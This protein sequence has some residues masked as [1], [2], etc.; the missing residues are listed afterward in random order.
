MARK[1]TTRAANGDG[2]IRQRPD[3]RWEVRITLGIDP[4]TGKPKRKSFYGSTQSE[5]RRKKTEALAA[6]DKG[7]YQEPS[8]IT[9]ESW[10]NTWLEEYCK[11]SVK[12][13]TL[14]SYNTI[15]NKHIIPNIGGLRLQDVRGVHIQKMYNKM[16]SN[17]NA[18]K[19]VKNIG[20]VLHKA[21]S[22]AV[23]QGLVIA[24]PCDATELPTM[25]QHEINPLSDTEIPLFIQAIKGHPFE[26]AYMLCLTLG[27]REGECLG[28]PWDNVD[29]DK[30]E[31][32]IAQQ[33]QKDKTAG[34][35]YKIVPFT[36]SNKPRSITLPPIAIECLKAERQKQRKNRIKAGSKWD[37]PYNLVFTNEF[38]RHLAIFTFYNNFKKVAASIGRPDLRP[39]DLRH[40]AATIVIAQGAD[41]KSVQSLLGHATA[42]FTLNVYA[43]T[44]ERMKEDTANRM[45]N[46]FDGVQKKG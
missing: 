22:I 12:P 14:S 3:G 37:N 26:G 5:V 20:A 45:Q 2:S 4:A 33:L 9:V 46:Y 23:K 34:G 32:I 1:A 39:H 29:L 31:L 38:G 13:Y 44:T 11:N 41:V 25:P 36:K 43:H 21:F 10:M 27:L 8:R 17:G 16:I 30:G 28:L 6:L 19:T 15:V 18:P 7:V 24:N 35:Q 42:S 40:T